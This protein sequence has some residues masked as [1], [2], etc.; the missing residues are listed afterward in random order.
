MKTHDLVQGTPE[1]D[2]FRAEHFTASEAPAMLGKSKFMTRNELLWL[3]YSGVTNET[4]SF[5]QKIYD[6][7]HAY[8][9]AAR[10]FAEKVIGDDLYPVTGTPDDDFGVPLSAS[11]DGL[12]MMEEI[13]FEHKQLNEDLAIK[14]PAKELDEMYA[15]QNEQGLMVSGADRCLFMAS[16]GEEDTAV[17]MWYESDP[18]LRQRIIDGWKQF[19][20]D[21]ENYEPPETIVEPIG[22]AIKDL[23]ALTYKFNGLALTSNLAQYRES[24]MQL[25]E[26]SRL[27]IETDQDFADRDTLVKKMK[28]A[29]N[30]LKVIKGLVIGEIEDVDAFCKDIDF[31]DAQFRRARLAGEKL[32]A[33]RK[34]EIR[35]EIA[36]SAM[37]EFAEFVDDLRSELGGYLMPR[38]ECN[39][40]LAMKGKR[41]VSS[42]QNAADTT[43]AEAKIEANK[44]TNVMRKNIAKLNENGDYNFLFNDAQ[45]AITKDPEHFALIVDQRINAHKEKEAEKLETERKRIREEEEKKLEADRE[46]IREEEAEKLR[47]EEEAKQLREAEATKEKERIS[48]MLSDIGELPVLLADADSIRLRQE[49]DS[50]TVAH[51]YKNVNEEVDQ[52]VKS[53]ID[54]LEAFYGH[55]ISDEEAEKLR[56]ETEKKERIQKMVSDLRE[57]PALLADSDALRIKQEMSLIGWADRYKNVSDEVDETV[58]AVKLDLNEMHEKAVAREREENE[59]E[60]AEAEQTEEG[61]ETNKHVETID[62]TVNELKDK[63]IN[64]EQLSDDL[65]E[66]RDDMPENSSNVVFIALWNDRHAEPTVHPFTDKQKAI[67]WARGAANSTCRFPDDLEECNKEYDNGQVFRIQYSCENDSIC[68]IKAVIDKDLS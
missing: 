52:A 10:P 53:A 56:L 59:R 5:Q 36:D 43:L 46:R 13:S 51:C 27:P 58:L 2:A 28:E 16:V 64:Q 1:W 65:D 18:E 31:I 44:I 24:A 22:S 4:T 29:E 21:L 7:G 62:E 50:L 48:K 9:E 63:P 67:D 17:W 38:I 14:I 25:V 34:V 49:I 30:K 40:A 66:L 26:D 3:K 42:L 41:T 55:A 68:V 11:F 47:L 23:P 39:A 45:A 6:Q 19:A 60:A 20:I 35:K 15:I 57:I 32:V 54:E 12:T 33:N 8:E 37:K 61:A